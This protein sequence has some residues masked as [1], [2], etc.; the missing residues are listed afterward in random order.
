MDTVSL[1]TWRR[2]NYQQKCFSKVNYSFNGS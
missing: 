1:M 2:V